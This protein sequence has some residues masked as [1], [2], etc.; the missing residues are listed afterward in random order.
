[1]CR[2]SRE[3]SEQRPDCRESEGTSVKN[4]DAQRKSR[5]LEQS[6]MILRLR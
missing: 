2:C 1:M 5:I 3:R 4:P 6:S